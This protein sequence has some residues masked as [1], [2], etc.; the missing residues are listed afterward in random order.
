VLAAASAGGLA[1][2]A[3]TRL[4]A[5]LVVALAASAFAASIGWAPTF[6]RLY[7]S[8]IRGDARAAVGP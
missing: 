1:G 7:R 8:E 5:P 4:G 6:W 2:L 3:A